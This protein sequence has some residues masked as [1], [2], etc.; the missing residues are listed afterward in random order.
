M[1]QITATR[2]KRGSRWWKRLIF[3]LLIFFLAAGILERP[4]QAA[5]SYRQVGSYTSFEGMPFNGPRGIAIDESGRIYVGENGQSRIVVYNPDGTENGKI[6]TWGRPGYMAIKDDILYM[7]DGSSVNRYDLNNNYQPIGEDIP[8]GY[9]VGGAVYGMAL[10][11]EGTMYTAGYYHMMRVSP[12]GQPSI[13]FD[14]STSNNTTD[15]QDVAIDEEDNLYVMSHSYVHKFDKHKNLLE[16]WHFGGNYLTGLAYHD[17]ALYVAISNS[18]SVGFRKISATDGRTLGEHIYAEYND[19]VHGLTVHPVTKDVYLVYRYGGVRVFKDAGTTV[20][21]AASSDS[22]QYGDAVTFD[23]SVTANNGIGTPM[24]T[25]ALMDGNIK[26][27]EVN[28][29]G[30]TASYTTSALHGGT[31]S[32]TAVYQGSGDH[33]QSISAAMVIEVARMASSITVQTSKAN[34]TW[35]EPA[36]FTATVN[37][38]G[39]GGEAPTGSVIFSSGTDV[40]G[41]GT[42]DGGQAVLTSDDLAVGTHTITAHFD[43]DSVF[44]PS[45]GTVLQT[46]AKAESVVTPYAAEYSVFGERVSLMASVAVSAP[47]A[48]MPTG[49]VAFKKGMTTLGVATLSEGWATLLVSDMEVGSH[50]I[51]VEYSGDGSVAGC[52]N[53]INLTVDKANTKIDVESSKNGIQPGESITF[54]ADVTVMSPG[55]GVPTGSVT[56]TNGQTTLGVA[57]LSGGSATL[58]VDSLEVGRHTI[59]AEY[60]GD[61][62]FASSRGTV[63][64]TVNKLDTTMVLTAPPGPVVFGEALVFTADVSAASGTPEGTVTFRNGAAVLGVE[65]LAD[66]KAVLSGVDDLGVGA[67]TITAEYDGSGRYA[68]SADTLQQAVGQAGTSTSVATSQAASVSGERVTFTATVTVEAPGAG[69]PGGSVTFRSGTAVLDTIMLDNGEATLAVSDLAVG[70]HTITAEYTGDDSFTGSSGDVDQTVDQADTAI[71][72]SSSQD[73]SVYGEPV[74]FTAMVTV[75]AP[76]AGV[77]SG[78]VTFRNGADTLDTVTLSGGVAT[79][80]VSDLAVGTHTITAEYTSDGSFA[81]SSSTVDQTVDQ[82]AVTLDV[83]SSRSVSVYGE[84]VMLTATL[85]AAPPG[86][87][88]PTG[89]VTFTNGSTTLGVAPLSGGSAMLDVDSLE[90]GT[91]TITAEYSG[92]QSF[93]SGSGTVEQMVNKLDTTMVLTAPPGPV[94]FGEALVF[95]ADVTAASGTPEGTVTFRNGAAVLGVEELADGKAVLSGVDD[96][97]VGTH[98]ITAEYDGSGRYAGSADTLQQAVGQAGTSTSVATLQ[99]ASVSGER[100][101]FTATVTVAAPGTGT[102]GGSV[103]FKNG[104]AVLDTVTLDDG[105]AILEVSDLQVGTHTI[106]AE[107][108]GDDSFA[109]SSGDVDQTVGKADTVI[110]VSSSQATSVSGELVTFTATVT[111]AAPGSGMPSGSVTF[112][113]GTKVLDTVPLDSGSATLALSNLAVGSHTITAEYRGDDSFGGSSSTVDQTVDQAAVTL[114][115]ASSRSVSVYGE[116]VTLTA[117]VTAVAPGAGTPTGSVTFWNDGEAIGTAPLSGGE[118]A[119]ATNELVVGTHTIT[120]EYSGDQSFASGS[121]TVEQTVNKLDTTMVLTVPPGPVVFG[122]AL[123]FTADVAAASGTPEGTVT[124]RNGAAVLGVEELADGKAVLSGVDDLAVGTHTITAEYDGSGRYAGSADTLQQAVGQAGTSTSVATSQAASVSG[125]RVTFTVAVTVEAPGAGTPGGSVTFRSG[126]AVLDTI[127]LDNGEATLAVS[128]LAVGTHTITAEYTGDDSF[129]GSS[130]DVDQTVDQ[131]DTTTSVATSQATSVS[132]ELVTFTATVTVA[133]PGSGMPSGSVT[134]RNGADTLDT[135]PLSGGVAT[136]EVSDLAVGTHTITAEYT[137]D[138]SFGGSSSTV[139]QTVDQ[140]EVTLDVAS[141]RSVSVYGE[142]VTLTAM[143]TAAPPGAGA[144]MGSVTFANGSTTLGVAPLSGGSATLDVDSLEVGTHTITVEYSGDNSFASGIGAITQEVVKAD[145]ILDVTASLAEV[146]YGERVSITATVAA[147]V[148]GKGTPT[149]TVTLQLGTDLIGSGALEDGVWMLL[150]DVLP[151]GNHLIDVHYSG[152]RSYAPASQTVAVTVHKADSI[153]DAVI[154]SE[155]SVAGETVSI[156][157]KVGADAPGSGMPSGAVALHNGT[158]TVGTGVL[159]DGEAVIAID[160]LPVGTYT[161]ELSYNGDEFFKASTSSPLTLTVGQGQTTAS[162]KAN[163]GNIAAGSPVALT[164]EILAVSPA[165]GGLTGTVTFFDQHDEIGEVVITAADHGVAE[166]RFPQGWRAGRYEI[167]VEYTGDESFY[168]SESE[169]FALVVNA[170]VSPP[171]LPPFPPSAPELPAGDTVDPIVNREGNIVIPP[172]GTGTVSL[173]ERISVSI[174]G[175]MSDTE[176]SMTIEEVAASAERVLSPHTLV[177]SIYEILSNL[178]G[179]FNK[180]ITISFVFDS[181]RLTSEDMVSIFYYDEDEQVWIDIGGVIDGNTISVSV[182][183]LTKFAVFA[184]DKRET[185]IPSLESVTFTDTGSHWGGDT[186][187]RAAAKGVVNGYPDGSFRPDHPVTRAEFLVMLS[188]VVQMPESSDARMAFTDDAKIGAWAQSAVYASQ[189]A[190]IVTGYSDG[191]FRPEAP[192]TRVE[193]AMMVARAL[194]LGVDAIRPTDFADDSLIPQWA[195]GAA[196]SVRGAGLIT[197]LRQQVCA[198]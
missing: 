25:V 173:G 185:E 8:V 178:E 39:P 38:A 102:P 52:S 3:A 30:G 150:T 165:A 50:T 23:I 110:T 96:L 129:T 132:G 159:V 176:I 17:G 113:N 128:D 100:V 147:A 72:V 26:V 49:D 131:A 170:P 195:K 155:T 134:F 83:T 80:E 51:T 139:D 74:T 119:V 87:G 112:R 9:L 21:A 184:V 5:A 182:D 10:D 174:P 18:S 186:I 194:G 61:Q 85:M 99:A 167:S 60:S 75:E 59:T 19:S 29:A 11:S 183:H 148:S 20:T 91:H 93:A 89:S 140:A 27:G 68:G 120:A 81:G 197:A 118:A 103:T 41:S 79:V 70:T 69:T 171:S 133:A 62:S 13:Y 35:G 15:G 191:S 73:T 154:S 198:L 42:L 196:A 146:V 55:A 142:E 144:P 54:Q 157:A 166:L 14:F 1:K 33:A 77:P 156:T 82:A 153:T 40:L 95:T 161:L 104:A 117:T 162:V 121:G 123:V 86:A 115:V 36:T 67:H 181:S 66:G 45:D 141:S 160:E 109:G 137:G 53:T 63:E 151:V 32:I 136:V 190:G 158:E 125:E 56:F 149:G 71:T 44:E 163:G 92:D 107:Y 111:V 169:S 168:G 16:S 187:R 64:Q 126:T 88:T 31:R 58:D 108:T 4:E 7:V 12:S 193:M 22:I 37:G 180:A 114:D 34:T 90:V 192:I 152:D 76:G 130:G 135:V 47:G 97:G 78:N 24:G 105:E 98:T 172:G 188:S 94:V 164:A 122:E 101:T 116:E 138:G 124:F 57:P 2:Q 177:S 175:E 189:Q 28:L 65:E 84:E 48:G 46:V 143:V 6:E 145:S 179:T 106:T 43:G 127:M